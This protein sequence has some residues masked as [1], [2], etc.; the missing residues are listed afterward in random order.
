MKQ[1]PHSDSTAVQSRYMNNEMLWKKAHIVQFIVRVFQTLPGVTPCCLKSVCIFYELCSRHYYHVGLLS[2]KLVRLYNIVTCSCLCVKWVITRVGAVYAQKPARSCA[3]VESYYLRYQWRLTWHDFFAST[4]FA[5]SL[6]P[7]ERNFPRD[8]LRS[9][10]ERND[11]LLDNGL[12][13]YHKGRD[14]FL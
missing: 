7:G 1:T 12:V 10:Q 9:P 14:P 11:G 4:D 5:V 13:C 6:R 8:S 2:R 3:D